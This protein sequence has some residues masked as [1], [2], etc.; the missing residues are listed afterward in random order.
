MLMTKKCALVILGAMLMIPP[1]SFAAQTRLVSVI[2]Q[3]RQM[4]VREGEFVISPD[5]QIVYDKQTQSLAADLCDRLAPA[6]GYALQRTDRPKSDAPRIVLSLNPELKDLGLE[7]YTLRITADKALLEAPAQAGLFYAMMSFLQLAPTEI[8]LSDPQPEVQ[9][10]VPCVDIRDR[11]RF[12]WRGMHLDVCRHFMPKE[13]VKKYIDLITLHKM[14]V[15]HWHL[16]DDQGWRIEIKKYPKLTEVGAWRKGTLIGNLHRDKPWRFDGKPHGGFYTQEEIREVVEYAARRHVTIVPEIEMPGHAQAAIAAYPELGTTG[17]PAEVLTYWGGCERIFNVEPETIAFLQ[18]VLTEVLDLF[19]SEFIH[20]GGDEVTK[21]PWK[22]SP[23]VQSRMKELGVATEEELQSWFIRQMDTFLATKGRR[24]VGW[25]EILQGGLAPGAT[26]MSW[27]G[28]DGGIAAAQ[29]GHDVI[30][31]P[32]THTYFDHYQGDPEHEPP[33][34]G[35]F[36]PLEHVYSFEPVPSVLDVGKAKH[37][38][39]AQ[40]QIWTEYIPTPEH[41]EYM[42]VPRM[43]ALAE[44]VWTAPEQKDYG[45]FCER[46]KSHTRRLDAMDVNYRPLVPKVLL[47]DP[48]KTPKINKNPGAG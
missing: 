5:T 19:P 7:G 30:M 11:P 47:P 15:F 12:A 26:V 42:A 18:D 38:L 43:C 29:A 45:R 4:Q 8:F 13:F 36:S 35:G 41:V 34:I 21:Q 33:A 20:I 16:T 3:P 28:M 32:G 40:G 48:E 27:R 25:D 24:L 9:W 6:M 1:S 10:T 2:P 44:V 31:A 39:G 17:E 14:N 46:L 22:D 23:R 37:V